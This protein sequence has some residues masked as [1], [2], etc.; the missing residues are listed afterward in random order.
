MTEK[1]I[2]RGKHAGERGQ[3][4]QAF[5]SC[6]SWQSVQLK[7]AGESNCQGKQAG[8]FS[9]RLCFPTCLRVG[10]HYHIANKRIIFILVQKLCSVQKHVCS[11]QD[12][13]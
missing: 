10:L 5:E 3:E 6:Q 1:N 8:G 9:L 2:E 13:I 12:P 7:R 4:E 11:V